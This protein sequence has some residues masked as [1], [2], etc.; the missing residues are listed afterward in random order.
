MRIPRIAPA[1]LL[2]LAAG[3]ATAAD[4][5]ARPAKLDFGPW[6]RLV[7]QDK[8]RMKPFDTLARET[9]LEMTGRVYFRPPAF[10]AVSA[11]EI[12]DWPSLVEQLQ[13]PPDGA[14]AEDESG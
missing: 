2:W 14:R 6:R 10:E 5:A 9:V 13:A 11:T 8:D 7:V 12:V 3:T 4:E 1:L